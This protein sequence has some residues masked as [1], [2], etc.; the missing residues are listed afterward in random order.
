MA[1]SA[2]RGFAPS[3]QSVTFTATIK[4]ASGS[5]PTGTVTFKDGGK[6]I[7]VRAVN[8]ATGQ[9]TFST[10]KLA[11]GRHAITASYGG[12]ANF[13]ACASPSLTQTITGVAASTTAIR[14]GVNP[15]VFGQSVALTAT[16]AARV[17]RFGEPTG[18]VI[19]LDGAVVL[20]AGKLNSSGR[21]SL[22][23]AALGVGSHTITAFYGGDKTFSASSGKIAE[24]VRRAVTATTLTSSVASAAAGQQV[25][26]TAKV[27]A[28]APG[29]GIASGS[30]TFRDGAAVLGT[31]KLNASGK[32]AFPI[33]TLATGAHNITASYLGNKDFLASASAKLTQTIT[34][35]PGFERRATAGLSVASALNGVVLATVAIDRWGNAAGPAQR[36]EPDS[37]RR[38]ASPFQNASPAGRPCP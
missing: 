1:T 37:R 3:G 23:T 9:A 27:T 8:A 13:I 34:A 32:A 31:V 28:R 2:A 20:G 29:A 21:A 25:T 35:A 19:F 11:I 17:A 33:S 30:V 14:T 22:S 24:I 36:D 26:F 38:P 18:S 15:S 5:G 16:V 7:G 12:N 4:P 10:S 6:T